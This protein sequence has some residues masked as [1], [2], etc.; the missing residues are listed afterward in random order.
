MSAAGGDRLKEIKIEREYLEA[1]SAENPP[2]GE[3]AATP[4]DYYEELRNHLIELIPDFKM[5]MKIDPRTNRPEFSTNVQSVFD[6]AW[7]TLARMLSEDT[8]PEDKGKQDS[9]P[10]GIMIR[11]RHCG[12]FIIRKGKRQEYCD[13]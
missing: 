7:Y 6:I 3:F 10:E 11:C 13:S 4:Y 8:A 5:R 9:R 12:R 1:H 2:E